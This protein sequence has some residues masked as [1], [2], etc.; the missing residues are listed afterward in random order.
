[1]H[2]S[3]YDWFIFNKR[4]KLI[5]FTNKKFGV[6]KVLERT[7]RKTFYLFKIN[8]TIRLTGDVVTR[9]YS[10]LCI[11]IRICDLFEVSIVWFLKILR[12]CIFRPFCRKSDHVFIGSRIL[13]T[14]SFIR[15][16]VEVD[17]I[18]IHHANIVR[19]QFLG[20]YTFKCRG[21]SLCFLVHT[22]FLVSLRR[23]LLGVGF[24][25]TPDQLVILNGSLSRVKQVSSSLSVTWGSLGT[26]L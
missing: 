19:T 16:D 20:L 25:T 22:L 24:W 7:G 5:S 3:K 9:T 18:D 26:S 17:Y 21:M 11:H 15:S 14:K 10:L 12:K 8:G 6:N 4:L 2:F 13:Y 1:M 23:L